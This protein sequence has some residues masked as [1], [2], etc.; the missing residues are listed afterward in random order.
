MKRFPSLYWLAIP[1]VTA[2]LLGVRETTRPALIAPD[3][4]E[5]AAPALPMEK[6]LP[7]TTLALA[8]GFSEP[9]PRLS[10]PA[11][12]VLKACFVSSQGRARALVASREGE[13]F[14]R[15][16]DKLPDGSVLRHID[17]RSITLWANGREAIVPLAGN[18]A[19]VFLPSG[20]AAIAVP[21][22]TESPRVLREVK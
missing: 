8:F 7:T 18:R 21:V 14:Y 15:V 6:P 16:G 10:S 9:G 4:L 22:T 5:H 20:N 19:G 12:L 13:R 17:V 1:V 11:E 2:L 3:A